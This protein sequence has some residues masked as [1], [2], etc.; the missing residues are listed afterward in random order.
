MIA[1]IWGEPKKLMLLYILKPLFIIF[2]RYV[3]GVCCWVKEIHGDTILIYPE[4]THYF[5]NSY[6]C[7]YYQYYKESYENREAEL[8]EF[9]NK[10][11]R[12]LSVM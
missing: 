4:T 7:P 2:F 9:K 11:K 5:Y 10:N 3:N 6:V 1:A 8:N 12:S